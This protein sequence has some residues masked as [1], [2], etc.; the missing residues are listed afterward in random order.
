[1]YLFI[2]FNSGTIKIE[3]DIRIGLECYQLI[4]SDLSSLDFV[5]TRVLMKLFKLMT[6][7]FSLSFI[8]E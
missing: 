6:V 5:I 2:E 8:I 1:M 7:V 4:K 3:L